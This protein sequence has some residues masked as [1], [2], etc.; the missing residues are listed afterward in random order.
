VREVDKTLQRS[1]ATV[2]SD[3]S[4]TCG[5]ADPTLPSSSPTAVLA[6]ILEIWPKAKRSHRLNRPS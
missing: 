2:S 1:T 6:L 5:P 4:T 3:V